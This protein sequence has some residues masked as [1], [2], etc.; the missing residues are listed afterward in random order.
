[1]GTTSKSD[2][3]FGSPL[4]SLVNAFSAREQVREKVTGALLSTDVFW[5]S[6]CSARQPVLLVC[7]NP[8]RVLKAS[9]EALSLLQLGD[10]EDLTAALILKLGDP[11]RSHLEQALSQK[12]FLERHLARLPVSEASISIRLTISCLP[13]YPEK[14]V[15]LLFLA[16]EQEPHSTAALKAVWELTTKLPYSVWVLDEKNQVI[17]ANEAF[18]H[19]PLYQEPNELDPPDEKAYALARNL[20]S[21]LPE[22]TRQTKKMLDRTV[23]LGTQ[24]TWRILTFLLHPEDIAARVWVMAF[25][26]EPAEPAKLIEYPK[27]EDLTPAS[28]M[29]VLQIREDERMSI[30]RE[31]HDYLGSELTVLRME[32]HRLKKAVSNVLPASD[33]INLYLNSVCNQID[34]LSIASRRIAYDLRQE[35]V[36]AYGLSQSVRDMVMDMRYR[37]G[38]AIQLEVSPNWIEPEDR[39]ARH[40]HRSLQ[41]LLN[42]VS[43]HAKATACL[44]RLGLDEDL[45]WVEVQDNG[46]GLRHPLPK[47]SV[48][49][50]SLKERSALF[51]GQVIVQ[52][53]PEIEGTCIRVTMKAR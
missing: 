30:G 32:V 25:K 2:T 42:N 5:R 36:K 10:V 52:S 13:E 33:Q 49:F 39:M 19:F 45:Y 50:N 1:M 34:K 38:L 11:L 20:L 18:N 9:N 40:M 28:L 27:R 37:I 35:F 8:F 46:I 7:S 17:Y 14:G 12:L 31:I 41:E 21:Q 24:G 4:Q 26:N 43:K 47:H 44:V 6:I 29:K 22:Q 51:G 23:E 48:G 3:S 53:R 15:G 16:P